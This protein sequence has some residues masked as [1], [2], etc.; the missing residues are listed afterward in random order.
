MNR[1]PF[2]LTLLFVCLAITS[3]HA[4]P[5]R[6]QQ[7]VKYIINA[8]MD[9]KANMLSGTEKLEYTNNSPDTLDRVFFHLYWNAFQPNSSMDVRSREL[10][11]TRIAEP[12]GQSDGLDWDS[13]VKDRISKLTNDQIGF[14]K[15]QSLRING[16]E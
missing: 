7:R 14:Q 4:Q 9:V 15:V 12:R 11:K 6:W 13:R 3:V 10:G 2:L 1:T 5:D 8:N 16:V